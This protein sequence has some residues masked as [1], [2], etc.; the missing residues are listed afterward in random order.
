MKK[1][2]VKKP[3][4][5]LS[6]M[7]NRQDR[8]TFGKIYLDWRK[9]V[10]GNTIAA[11]DAGKAGTDKTMDNVWECIARGKQDIKVPFYVLLIM[12]PERL[13][14]GWGRQQFAFVETCPTPTYL[15]TVWKYDP[16][17]N[18]LTYLWSLPTKKRCFDMYQNK[19]FVPVQEYELLTHVID[20]IEGKL[21][22]QAAE[23]NNEKKFDPYAILI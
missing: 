12:R 15:Q 17:N 13:F 9:S 1:E 5:I 3:K 18:Q 10:D 7:T 8:E 2:E 20:F 19:Q 23:L 4:R 14:P 6:G 11:E 21:D 16:R 22:K